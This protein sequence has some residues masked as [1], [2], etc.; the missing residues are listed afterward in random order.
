MYGGAIQRK[1]KTE[2]VIDFD[3]LKQELSDYIVEGA[4]ERYQFG[5]TPKNKWVKKEAEIKYYIDL[6]NIS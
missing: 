4:G 2:L 3:K 6:S 1:T 5:I